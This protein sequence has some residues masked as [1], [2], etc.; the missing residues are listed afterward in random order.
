MNRPR[1]PERSES[2]VANDNARQ[3]RSPET[4]PLL[5]KVEVRLPKALPVQI[6]EVEVFAELL[7]SLPPSAN[8]NG[9]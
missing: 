3:P 9:D 8:D 1:D 7:D 4:K 6:V 2:P 5:P